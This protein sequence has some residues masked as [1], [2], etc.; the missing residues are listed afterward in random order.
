[1]ND[2][3]EYL[4]QLAE[5]RRMMENSSKFMSLSGFSGVFIGIYALCGSFF[6]WKIV[7]S[8]QLADEQK[9]FLLLLTALV[10]L[11]A[12]LATA[13]LLTARKS[14][15]LRQPLWGTGSK[16][17]LSCLLVPLIT[18]GI[19]VLILVIKGQYESV[20]SSLLIFYGLAL[21]CASRFVTRELFFMGVIQIGLGLAAA[22]LNQYGLI[23]WAAGFGLVHI[24]YGI[25][26]YLK[27]E[28]NSKTA[29]R[30]KHYQTPG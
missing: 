10:V 21:T 25:Y 8:I 16:Q 9:V 5:I 18:G 27:Y 22:F 3:S 11:F 24:I 4:G 2:H 13:V 6:A 29:R 19:F 12:A 28:M 23:L 30:E 14:K 1:M 17:L 20:A 7:H 15:K 26:M